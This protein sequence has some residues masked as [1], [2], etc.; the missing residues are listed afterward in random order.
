MKLSIVFKNVERH[1]PAEKELKHCSAKLDRLLK[2]F[3]PDLVQ[4]H[5]V[6]SVLP[7][8]KKFCLALKLTIPTGVL[9][10]SD[11]GEHLPAAC[12]SAFADL[13]VQLKKHLAHLRKHY[14]WKRRRS[15]EVAL[16]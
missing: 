2:N 8:T 7:R 4:L 5:C 10:A 6:F 3:D 1:N 15:R 11:E 9:H 14:E 16:A 13:S 12:K